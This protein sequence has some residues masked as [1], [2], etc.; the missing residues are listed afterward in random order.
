MKQQVDVFFHS[1]QPY[2]YVRDEDLA[3]VPPEIEWFANITNPQTR[4][5]YQNDLKA[6]MRFTGINDPEVFRVV[7]RTHLIA[8]RKDLEG[9]GDWKVHRSGPS[10]RPSHPCSNISANATPWCT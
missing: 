3:D 2:T 5:A 10:C 8:W 7:T 9:R 1:Q 4:R 6:F